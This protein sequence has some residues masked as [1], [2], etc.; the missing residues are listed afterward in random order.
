MPYIDKDLL[1]KDLEESVR[2]S[3]RDLNTSPE[4]RG[5]RKIVDRIMHVPTVDVL[6][7]CDRKKCPNCSYPQCKHTFDIKH[8]KNFD[9]SIKERFG[10]PCGDIYIE[11][12]ENEDEQRH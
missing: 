11:K 2:F 6:Y 8:A 4:V 7:L 12:E 10:E 9:T 1:L 3:V 5:A